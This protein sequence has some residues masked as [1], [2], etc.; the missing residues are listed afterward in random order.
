MSQI[1]VHRSVQLL[2]SGL[3]SLAFLA[4][5]ALAQSQPAKAPVLRPPANDNFIK[6]LRFA[7][8]ECGISASIVGAGVEDFEPKHRDLTPRHSVWFYWKAPQ[9]GRAN[10]TADSQVFSP[11]LAVYTC[12]D[13]QGARSC[14]VLQNL[15]PVPFSKGTEPSINA[16]TFEAQR[17]RIYYLAV[18][19]RDDK[20]GPFGLRHLFKR[21]SGLFR[22]TECRP[23]LLSNPWSIKCEDATGTPCP[24]S[25]CSI[26]NT[27]F[28][29]YD[30]YPLD[31]DPKKR[32]YT[33][34][35]QSAYYTFCPDH[36]T[37]NYSEPYANY[38]VKPKSLPPSKPKSGKP[39]ASP[40]KPGKN[41]TPP[42]Q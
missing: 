7:P 28:S 34:T 40:A 25:S 8:C 10:F 3:A 31:S 26:F 6:A 27:G 29:F 33:L 39:A 9:N 16:Y 13:D 32:P 37:H 24:S 2:F 35:P 15:A 12:R 11:V 4:A 30:C 22:D 36:N 21:V 20:T 42:R 38:T 5:S 41:Q 23:L 17:D 18:D 1:S 14:Q 19:S